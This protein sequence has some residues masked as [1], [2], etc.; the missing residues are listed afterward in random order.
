MAYQ[1]LLPLALDRLFSYTSDQCIPLG[2]LVSVPFR[3][4]QMTGVVWAEAETSYQGALKAIIQT[5][6]WQ[7]TPEMCQ[8][9]TWVSEYNLAPIGAVLKMVL[10]SQ[11]TKG[12]QPKKALS[13]ASITPSVEPAILSNEQQEAVDKIT[14]HPDK[15]QVYLLDGV[16][17]SGK[18]EVYFAALEKLLHT[19]KQ[20]LI[21]L[22]EIALTSQWLARFEQRF[23]VAPLQWHSNLTESVRRQTWQAIVTGQAQV[24]VGARSALFLPFLNLGLI[25]VDEEHDGSYKQ[26]EQV[27][28]HARDMAVKRAHLNNIPI[29]LASATPSLETLW[30]T[31]QGRYEHLILR[32]RYGKAKLPSLNFIDMRHQPKGWISPVL[33][34]AVSRT[35]QRKEQAILFLNRRGYAPLTLCSQC[36]HR[37]TCPGC[38][39]WLVEHK[40]KHYLLCH[41]CDFQ[42]QRPEVCPTCQSTESFIPC[43][44]GVERILEEAQ[45]KFPQANIEILTSDHIHNLT[46]L[47]QI[48]DRVMRQEIDILIGTQIL[49]KG[50]HFPMITLVGVID[51]DLGLTGSDL[52]A[53]ERTYQLLHQV[54]GRAGRDQHPGQVLLQTFNPHHPLFQALQHY[55]R[56]RFI[57]VETEERQNHQMP[58]FGRLISLTVSSLKTDLATAAAQKLAATAPHDPNITILGPAPAPFAKLRGRYRWRFL[59]KAPKTLFIQPVIKKW[60]HSTQNLGNV[61]VSIDVDPYTF[62]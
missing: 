12:K 13:I 47:R 38:S 53:G 59:I 42:T 26:E 24:V 41:Y 32:N 51:A 35:L 22:P 33:T 30:N 7:I 29:V 20:I 2:Q 58:P 9:I 11:A 57:A 28:Y 21:L 52:R 31:Q 6:P 44:P 8:F 60:L 25:I 40:S 1:V 54:A 18:T 36:G 45:Q 62:S 3:S 16:T 14:K 17:G 56:E 39:A 61:K 5:L 10:P 34:A 23:G 48:V 50:Y 49:A 55:D 27:I 19:T 4:S 43:G 46:Q 37:L 15:F